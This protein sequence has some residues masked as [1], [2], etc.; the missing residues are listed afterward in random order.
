[1]RWSG[2]SKFITG[3]VLAILLLFIVGA[4]LTH[5]LLDLL[6]NSTGRRTIEQETFTPEDNPDTVNSATSSATTAPIAEAP[7]SL[8]S[9]ASLPSPSPQPYQA[10]VTQLLPMTVRQSPQPGTT[11][12]GTVEY[13]QTVIVLENSADGVWQKIRVGNVEGWI[14]SGNV[15][16]IQ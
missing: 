8:P 4:S 3:F 9:F 6:V 10:R 5:Y 11:Q 7:S 12:V 16:P 2:G 1:M 13:N 14:R 15:Q